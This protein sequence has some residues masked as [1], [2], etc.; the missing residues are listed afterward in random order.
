MN[1]KQ[2]RAAALKAAQDIVARAKAEARDLTAEEAAQVEAKTAEV[3]E[4]DGLIAQAAKSA[5]LVS[6]VGGL[7]PEEKAPAPDG[8]GSAAP[9]S[10]GEHF[11]KHAGARLKEIKGVSGASVA[12]PEYKAAA[13]THV[14]TGA[15][16][17]PLITQVDR[18]LV[19]GVRR[20]LYL[21]DLLGSGSLS[22]SA[23]TYF[24]EG[25]LEGS[26]GWVAE[27]GQKPQLHQ[28][29]PTP[30]TEALKEI[31]GFAKYSDNMLE[32]LDFLVSEINNRMLYEL[33]LA[34]EAGLLNGP[35]TGN[36]PLGIL[37]RSGLQT[38]TAADN[39]DNA[40]AI[41]R[42]ITKV[43]LGSGLEADGVV[44]NPADYQ[45]LRLSK[46][47][48]GQYYGGGFFAGQYGNG[49]NIEVE[50][51][52]WGRRTVVTPSIAA[53][54]VLVGAFSQAATVY[55]KGGVKVESTNSHS[56]DFTNDRVT[57]RVKERLALAVRRPAGFVRV[58]LSNADPA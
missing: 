3:K 26:L 17:A 7:A 44:I 15:G 31:A 52:L 23:I 21:A 14:T 33:G 9:K 57:I 51:P 43:P 48:N 5:E 45:S 25:A 36:A 40:D 2:K 27:A 12:A 34:E 29:D 38:E 56:D 4:L 47:G 41:F 13:D 28:A 8:G 46:D 20:R 35:G 30:V 55:R 37:G 54:T 22:G 1:L 18:S 11:V 10:L 6:L 50:P 42:A 16:L 19:L 24:V 49:S 53:G 32:D 39:T 58:T